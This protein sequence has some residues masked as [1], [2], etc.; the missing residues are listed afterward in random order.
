L[1]IINSANL[2]EVKVSDVLRT[3]F[4]RCGGIDSRL[5]A[6]IIGEKILDGTM[7]R[8]SRTCLARPVVDK[9]L[10]RNGWLCCIRVVD[11][12]ERR[13]PYALNVAIRRKCYVQNKDQTRRITEEKAS[14]DTAV[15]LSWISIDSF[16]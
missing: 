10:Q 5:R 14:T 6:F 1:G 12:H 3:K 4:T 13:F 2:S 7:I 16:L 15:M 11:R 9:I 8:N